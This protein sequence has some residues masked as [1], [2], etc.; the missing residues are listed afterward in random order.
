MAKLVQ[1]FPFLKID[2]EK[3]KEMANANL[4]DAGNFNIV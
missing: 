2:Y 4:C 1:W 3:S